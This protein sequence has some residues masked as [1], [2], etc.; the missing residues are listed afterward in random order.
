MKREMSKRTM[1]VRGTITASNQMFSIMKP[2]TNA[3]MTHSVWCMFN[4]AAI[5]T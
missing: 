3:K 1:T 2:I 4:P 5:S